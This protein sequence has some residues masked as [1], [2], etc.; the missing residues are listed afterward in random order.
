MILGART[1]LYRTLNPLREP[2]LAS[3][4]TVLGGIL[5]NGQSAI[6]KSG[7]TPFARSSR[8]THDARG[9]RAAH[10]H[11]NDHYAVR[12]YE[13]RPFHHYENGEG[14]G[15]GPCPKETRAFTSSSSKTISTQ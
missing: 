5:P 3:F 1:A 11:D 10:P 6:F 12:L 7:R 13:E 14:T 15:T 9:L 4:L 2:A 8:R